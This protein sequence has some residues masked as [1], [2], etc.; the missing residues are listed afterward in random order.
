MVYAPG[1]IIG[2]SYTST[3]TAHISTGTTDGGV[4][5]YK[6]RLRYCI[7]SLAVRDLET[8]SVYSARSLLQS[9]TSDQQVRFAIGELLSGAERARAAI[10]AHHSPS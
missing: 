4:D 7:S 2:P 3:A 6:Q 9:L 1:T 5:N 10:G 8:Q